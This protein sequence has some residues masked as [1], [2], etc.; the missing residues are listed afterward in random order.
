MVGFNSLLSAYFIRL[1]DIL[2]DVL[3]LSFAESLREFLSIIECNLLLCDLIG[4]FAIIPSYLWSTF[5]CFTMKTFLM[6]LSIIFSFSRDLVRLTCYVLRSAL[7]I[8][9]LLFLTLRFF[10]DLESY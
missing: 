9:S 1:G 4:A 7:L 10:V 6:G 5:E 3:Y 8:D 2:I